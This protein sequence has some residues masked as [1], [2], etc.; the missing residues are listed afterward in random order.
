[1]IGLLFSVR[2]VE[3]KVAGCVR[4]L[5]PLAAEPSLYSSSTNLWSW[6]GSSVA[7]A[8]CVRASR[9]AAA[10]SGSLQR[11]GHTNCAGGRS[12]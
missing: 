11:I 2:M 8:Q 9:W 12:K 10:T 4:S 7:D 1:M 6:I 3:F 5:T